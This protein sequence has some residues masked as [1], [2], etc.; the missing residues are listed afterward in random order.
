VSLFF[1]GMVG[2]VD[3]EPQFVTTASFLNVDICLV[4]DRSTSMKSEIDALESGMY[5]N[6]PRF[7]QPPGAESRWLALDSAVKV[8]TA[9][10][11]DSNAVEQV[12]LASY[13]TA[14]PQYVGKYCGF[15]NEAA[16][17]DL[18]LAEDLDVVDARVTQ[19]SGSVWNGNTNIEAGMRAGLNV[20]QNDANLRESADK[21]M[22]VMTDGNETV[23]SAMAAADDC[24]SAKIRVHTITFGADANQQLMASVASQC[25][26]RHFHADTEQ[27]LAAAFRELAAQA[28]QLT[29]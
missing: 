21:M 20:L 15:S 28:A 29:E 25:G 11:R 16:S 7:C 24:E 8:F 13:S 27:E 26:G 1:G 5:S 6:D 4:L 10:L 17:I 14:E 3:F 19:L 22:I 9:T 23:G 12:A 2:V 18:T